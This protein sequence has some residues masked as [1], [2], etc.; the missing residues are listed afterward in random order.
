MQSAVDHFDD[1]NLNRSAAKEKPL[2]KE[3]FHIF[4]ASS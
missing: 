2:L 1:K 3:R 4:S